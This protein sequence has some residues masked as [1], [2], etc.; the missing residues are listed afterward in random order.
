ML[1]AASIKQL[2]TNN[3]QYIV[4]QTSQRGQRST[5]ADSQVEADTLIISIVRELADI[6]SDQSPRIKIL[7]PDTDVL[8]LALYLVSIGCSS[9]IEFELLNSTARRI[10]PVTPLV[11]KLREK[12][13]RALLAA[14]ILT[15]CDQIGK[16]STVTKDR[17]F[18]VFLALPSDV[19]DRLAE[20]GDAFQTDDEIT[21]AVTRYVMLLYARRQDDRA[22]IHKMANIGVL[23]WRLYS[24]HQKETE[25]LPP[26]PISALNRHIQR[27]I[28]VTGLLKLSAKQFRPQLPG[29]QEH[30]WEIVQDPLSPIMTDELPRRLLSTVLRWSAA[31][32]RS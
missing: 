30:G 5:V 11:P 21:K 6:L 13:A 1:A 20:M 3:K 8:I 7:S 9:N 14:Y 31:V 19:I 24:K 12:K 2:E 32:A 15:G 23:R 16:F 10:I 25:S 26:T 22:E 4:A 18:K 27:S 29:L 28:F 17:A